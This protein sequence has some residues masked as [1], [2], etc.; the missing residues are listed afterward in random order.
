MKLHAI[1][2]IPSYLGAGALLLIPT[3]QAQLV[4]GL[5]NYWQF[6]NDAVDVAA[7]TP[8]SAS[9]TANDG[10]I[11]G[12]VTFVDN[13]TADLGEG[14]G[15]AAS[16]TGGAQNGFR[17]DDP[18][19][20]D[21]T[22]P[23]TNDID[24]FGADVSISVWVRANTWTIRFQAILGHG[25]DSDYR[26]A[27]LNANNPIGF[28]YAGGTGDIGTS[29]TYGSA[30][31]GD[32]LWHHIVVTTAEAGVTQLY[33]DGVLEATSAG[34]PSIGISGND[35]NALGLGFN[36]DTQRGFDGLMDDV[37]MWNRVLTAQEVST[38]YN[39]GLDGNQL[40]VL[41]DTS[42]NDGDGL[43]NA[44]EGQ[45]G[46]DP[47]DDGSVD[48]D[49]GA[50]GDPDNDGSSNIDEFNNSTN[51]MDPDSDGDNLLDGV[52]TNTG[53]FNDLT[54]TGTNPLLSDTDGD[55][56]GDGVEN[57]TGLFV[58]DAMTGTNPLLVDTD[59]DTLPDGY[60]VENQL[61]PTTDDAAL[62]LDGDTVSNLDEFTNGT[63]PNALDTD[64]DGLNDNE[65][66]PNGDTDPLDSD[67]DNDTLLDGE[68]VNDTN[69]NPTVGDTDGD[70][71]HD[72]AEVLASRD[73][74]VADG[75]QSGFSQRLVAYWNFDNNL[76]DIAE[77]L[78]SESIVADNG[79][80]TGPETDVFFA[81]EGLFGESALELNGG[82]GWVTV[83]ASIDTL[84]EAENAVSVSAWVRVPA[85]T[86]AWQAIISH[87]E[88]SQWRLARQRTSSNVAWAGGAGDIIGNT[89]LTLDVW[90]HVVGISDPSGSVTLYINGVQAA[91]GGA[92]AITDIGSS[93][94]IPD[95]FIGANPDVEGREWN[96]LI[97][98]VAIWGR[99]IS[100]E[101]IAMIFNGGV[102]T[103][104]EDLLVGTAPLAITDIDF[105]PNDGFPEVSLTWNS[106]EGVSY[107]I[108]SSTD[109]IN[110][111]GVIAEGIL[112]ATGNSTNFEL[113]APANATRLFYRVELTRT[114]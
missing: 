92:P 69:T 103:S 37:A 79:T 31:E 24:R 88:N 81:A 9:E 48:P 53:T 33:V 34:T 93:D 17:V 41:L 36:P 113:S 32:G 98:D 91:T 94:V 16:F 87:G 61:D 35:S 106:Q 110:F 101:E 55:G 47:N 23:A 44:F 104:I 15:M 14:F 77:T 49:N 108:Y 20:A 26:L 19:I 66:A 78:P 111:D 76:D 109:L 10:V 18:D 7:T 12:T 71:T 75:I 21:P 112:G 45:F 105:N 50:T 63:N 43:P 39:T 51:P 100:E 46:L 73:P 83:P 85:F 107:G 60:E 72:G 11:S 5:L 59:E 27:R 114:P 40:A 67:S 1:K 102:G 28:A 82:A 68:E 25:E 30:P 97:D 57:G 2:R 6:E 80:F 22:L 3:T 4:D 29:S 38:I 90:Q 13:V 42:D 64:A 95:L 54:D 56:L 8:G 52:E 99:A 96:G 70:G 89:A 84:R 74:N 65:E 86:T 62:D 58:S